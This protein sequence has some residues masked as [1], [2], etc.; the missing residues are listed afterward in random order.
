MRH[1]QP[2]TPF[3]VEAEEL[4]QQFWG[5][6]KGWVSS[7]QPT[8]ARRDE[9]SARRDDTTGSLRAIRDGFAAFRPQTTATA[10]GEIRRQRHHGVPQRPAAPESEPT[11]RREATLG[12]L[13]AGRSDVGGW[14][15]DDWP[16][17]WPHDRRTAHTA[18][19]ER[20][21]RDLD[22]P[23]FDEPDFD[24]PLSPVQPLVERLG[25]GAVDPLLVRAG[26][27]AVAL[28]LLVPIMISL[29]PDRADTLPG[30]LVESPQPVGVAA[31]APLTDPAATDPASGGGAATDTS[32]PVP[33][34]VVAATTATAAPASSIQAEE[35]VAADTV[36]ESVD[37]RSTVEAAAGSGQSAQFDAAVVDVAA[38]R[39]APVCP[40]TYTAA[41]GD[42]W[43]RIADA[44]G[45]SPSELLAG[46]DATTATVI[47]PGD[48]ICLPEG[49]T[50]PDPPAPTAPAEDEPA[51][52]TAPPTTTAPTTTVAPV[53]RLSRAE[54]Q[55]LIR[56]TWPD[57]EVA[58]ALAVAE[59]ESNFVATAD[60]GWC[61]V[62]VFQLYWTVHRSWLDDF[63]ITERSHLY[64]ARKNI[65][66]AFHM[67]QTQG[68]GP[69]NV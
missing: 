21:E 38:E 14:L 59:R 7:E 50:V 35:P 6:T 55:E 52:T 13:A 61:C 29:R 51:A 18:R 69:W 30:D 40:Q 25:L 3:D 27:I 28:L 54:V 19:H 68:W 4:T 32:S 49:A 43:Y 39:L 45:V 24:V 46:N 5:A 36:A 10:T 11:G 17:E 8:V 65:A 42:S 57:E 2:T 58:T 48:E 33:T 62:G 67:W 16:D 34:T 9:R 53:A 56:A 12:E 1:D 37:E 22:E 47:L 23:D 60:N 44:A 64:D 41:A 20:T 63:G 26:M 15:D 66:A 31:G